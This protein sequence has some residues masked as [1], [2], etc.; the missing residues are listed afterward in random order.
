L[1]RSLLEK[2]GRAAEK[3]ILKA[4]AAIRKQH[5][6]FETPSPPHRSSRGRIFHEAGSRFMR[7]QTE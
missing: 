3:D 6:F 5:L 7:V 4:R 1:K 2:T